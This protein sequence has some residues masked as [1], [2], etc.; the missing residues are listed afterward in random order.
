ME[1]LRACE[2]VCYSGRFQ[3]HDPAIG[4]KSKVEAR[5]IAS[6][7]PWDRHETGGQRLVEPLRQGAYIQ[8]QGEDLFCCCISRKR[9]GVQSRPADGRVK[10]DILDG[11]RPFRGAPR[12]DR[13]FEHGLH[14]AAETSMREVGTLDG[15]RQNGRGSQGAVQT[16]PGHTH[17]FDGIAQRVDIIR[18]GS[19]GKI[20]A[21]EFTV[22]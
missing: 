2:K 13:V 3:G 10:Q 8:Q 5:F 15:L 22:Q 11:K 6:L 21:A 17:F 14:E 7:F 1:T 20:Y 12:K 16:D 19:K 9:N 18:E 4:E